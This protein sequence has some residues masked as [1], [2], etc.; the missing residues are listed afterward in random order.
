MEAPAQLP[1]IRCMHVSVLTF[2]YSVAADT[3]FTLD[4]TIEC[5]K[6]EELR[7]QLADIEHITR[8]SAQP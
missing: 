3:G 5:S 8:M 2:L 7:V 6:R 1:V 4:P